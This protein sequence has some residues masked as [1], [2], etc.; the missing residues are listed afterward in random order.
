MRSMTGFGIG[1]ASLRAGRLSVEVRSLNHRFLDVR[2]RLP[3]E[4]TDHGFFVEQLCRERLVRGRY[5][6]S[7][8]VDT[9]A[10]SALEFDLD[11]ARSAY[12][13]L[14]RLR[15]EVAPTSE[16]PLSLLGSFPSLLVSPA[17]ADPESLRH[18]LSTGIGL[19]LDSL[20]EMRSAEGR[21]L[22]AELS[23]RL[24]V[25]R[26]LLAQLSDH[27]PALAEAQ[28]R[29]LTQRLE[30]LLGGAEGLEPAR[31]ALEVAALADRSD[32]TEELVRLGSHFDQFDG[33]LV[34][35][36]PSGRKLDF[37]LQ[38]MARETNTIG[39]KCQDATLSH[40]VVSLKTELERLREQVQNIE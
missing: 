20:D 17:N 2:V 18:A 29:R 1:E 34:T 40:L 11:R 33:C 24:R 30:R 13:A 19:A 23:H 5:D 14:C 25:L 4:L 6:I 12:A 28:Q 22:A 32:I 10:L 26:E 27:G 16:V 35:A 7:V 31:L 8:K 21:T 37:L 9:A 36:G 39:A 3:P 15:D 38:E